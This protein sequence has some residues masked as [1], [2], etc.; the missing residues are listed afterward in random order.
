MN[1][2]MLTALRPFKKFCSR[3]CCVRCERPLCASARVRGGWRRRW[4]DSGGAEQREEM[5]EMV[6]VCNC[7]TPGVLV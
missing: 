2:G 6:E 3:G 1:E 4:D 7:E 5:V